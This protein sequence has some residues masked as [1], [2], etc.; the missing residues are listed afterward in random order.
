M[1]P[2]LR[3]KHHFWVNYPFKVTPLVGVVVLTWEFEPL[4]HLPRV[5]PAGFRR[6]CVRLRLLRLLLL[7]C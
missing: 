4:G 3:V 7:L 1:K 6:L 5:A 2:P